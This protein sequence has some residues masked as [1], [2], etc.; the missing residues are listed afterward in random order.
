M[1]DCQGEMDGVTMR[2]I[3]GDCSLDTLR[4][5]LSQAGY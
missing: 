5:E 2:Y 1:A 3:F 4:Y